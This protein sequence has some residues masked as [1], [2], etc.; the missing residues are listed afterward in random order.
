M[1]LDQGNDLLLINDTLKPSV[2]ELKWTSGG[3][4]LVRGIPCETRSSKLGRRITTVRKFTS[5]V[6]L[7]VEI[8]LFW[9]QQVW[10][11][12]GWRDAAT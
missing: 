10:S 5:G 2:G 1:P 3:Y 12:V 11:W 9:I 6:H 4:L 7:P 8:R